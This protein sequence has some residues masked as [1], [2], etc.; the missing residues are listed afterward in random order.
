MA[1][2][3]TATTATTAVAEYMSAYSLKG[4][5]TPDRALTRYRHDLGKMTEN[6]EI[7]T[8]PGRYMLDAPYRYG[9]AAFVAEPTLVNQRWGASHDMS[10]TKTDVESDLTNR[11]RPRARTT[12]GQYTPGADAAAHT[13]TSMPEVA[14]PRSWARLTDPPATLR[15]TGWNRWEW[16]CQNP[17]DAALLPFEHRVET[18][19]AAKDG[20]LKR[21]A[22]GSP[23]ANTA[24]AH[25]HQFLCTELYVDPAVPVA[26]PQPKGA[27]ENFND[28]VPGSSSGSQLVAR[29]A[30]R[31][32]GASARTAGSRH[33]GPHDVG[34]ALERVRAETG[35]M[36]AP[37]PFTAMSGGR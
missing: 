10:S 19:L 6:N 4:Q 13:L 7:S 27:P 16:L 23:L 11:G 2:A 22:V 21:L 29:E 28:K 30:P 15:G 1:A 8:G 14:W 5:H 37:P 26:K 3:T 18:R 35:V 34:A 12:C 24:V 31:I 20:F 17:Q 36:A 33:E 25:D 9:N 32:H